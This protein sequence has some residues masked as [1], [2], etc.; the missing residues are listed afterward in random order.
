VIHGIESRACTVFRT[1]GLDEVFRKMGSGRWLVHGQSDDQE[2]LPT[3]NVLLLA[4]ALPL[5]PGARTPA[6]AENNHS[7]G[8]ASEYGVADGSSVVV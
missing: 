3:D 4:D 1:V 6:R 7:Q 5:P 2:P 8:D